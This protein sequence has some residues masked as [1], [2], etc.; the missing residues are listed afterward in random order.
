VRWTRPAGDPAALEL[1][2]RLASIVLL[3]R[4]M[5]PWPVRASLLAIAATALLSR[6]V[7]VAPLTWLTLAVLVA[8]RLAAEWPLPDNHIYLLAYWCL[9]AAIA[10]VLPDPQAA[11][12]RSSRLLVGLAFACAVIWKAGLSGDYLDGRFFRVTLLTDDRFADTAVLVGGLSEAQLAENRRYLAPLPEGAELLHPPRL[13][14]PPRLRALAAL[15]TWGGLALE[16][17]AALLFLLPGGSG[18]DPL[19]HL[20]LLCFCALTY[21]VAPVAGFGWLLLV[22]GLVLCPPHHRAL[23]GTYVAAF[24]LVLLYAEVP[25]AGAALDWWPG[26]SAK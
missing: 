20:A 24:L 25:W 23:R 10:L 17:A 8:A 18:R 19:R 4:P 13:V 21:A 14:E 7:L 1:P 5:G 11:L 6:R 15:A 9:A 2:F 3:L 22:M 16:A 12:A 26:L